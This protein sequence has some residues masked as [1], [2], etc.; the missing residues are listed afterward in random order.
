[1]VEPLD[2]ATVAFAGRMLEPAGAGAT[3]GLALLQA[4]RL[5]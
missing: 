5:A 4:G 3:D 1:V 2:D